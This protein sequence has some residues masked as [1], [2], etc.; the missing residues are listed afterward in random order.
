MKAPASVSVSVI[1]TSRGSKPSF[2]GMKPYELISEAMI[3]W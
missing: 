2:I 3:M 1:S